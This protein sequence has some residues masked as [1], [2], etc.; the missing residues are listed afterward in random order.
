MD[1]SELTEELK[2][3]KKEFAKVLN[4]KDL[5]AFEMD[6]LFLEE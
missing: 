5:S 1:D 6:E 2:K 4:K 3:E